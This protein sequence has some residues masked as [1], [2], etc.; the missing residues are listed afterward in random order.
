MK[1]LK[2]LL[3][4]VMV[5]VLCGCGK[6]KSTNIIDKFESKVNSTKSYQIT[7]TMEIASNEE[8]FSYDVSV[9]YKYDEF[10]KVTL[11]NKNNNHEQVILKDGES[12]YVVTPALNKSFKFQS[13][14]PEN[15]SQSYLLKSLL[16]DIK[17][18][19]EPKVDEN[20]DYYI[21]NANV[22][23]PNNSKLKTEKIYFDKDGNLKEVQ[24][25]NKDGNAIIRM[26]FSSIK[27][28][29]KFDDKNF[30]LDS[31]I[32]KCEDEATCK[33]KESGSS[34]ETGAINDIIYPL[35]LPEDTHLSTKDTVTTEGSDRVIMTY[36]GAKPFMIIEEP[37]S[38]SKEME[39]TSV[40]GEPLLLSSAV[41]AVGNNSLEWQSNNM[42]YY[43]TSSY[44]SPE[45]MMTIAESLNTA[46]VVEI[47]NDK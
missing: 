24:V 16:N 15:S 23:Y 39:I 17:S 26:K 35:Y 28:S 5:V 33:P 6:A 34:A 4:A 19:N 7:G 32:T 37:V 31:L 3:L 41:A 9:D 30:S 36:A 18:T 46:S 27:Y 11:L 21:V 38:T 43:I 13:E 2:F 40:S 22:N 20:D 29:V 42:S 25:L 14:W 44:L 10:Y 47:T 45:E 8:T 12:V 1:K